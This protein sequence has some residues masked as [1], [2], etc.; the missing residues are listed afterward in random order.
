LQHIKAEEKKMKKQKK[1]LVFAL[2]AALFVMFAAVPA[3][4]TWMSNA[5]INHIGVTPT[6]DHSFNVSVGAWT[7]T[8]TLLTADANAN[9]VLAVLLT[10]ASTGD[11]VTVD[12]TGSTINTVYY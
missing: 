7:K 8:F 11:T 4:A 2:I 3:Q 12:F 9:A 10:A 1:F 6:G 5:T